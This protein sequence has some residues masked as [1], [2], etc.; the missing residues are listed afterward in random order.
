MAHAN[1]ET[2]TPTQAACYDLIHHVGADKVADFLGKAAKSVANEANPNYPDAKLGFEDMVEIEVWQQDYR[3]LYA[4][5][6]RCHHVCLP[7]P[8][9]ERIVADMAVLESFAEWQAALGMTCQEIRDAL[10]DGK[11]TRAEGRRITAAFYEHM[12]RGLEFLEHVHAIEEP[13]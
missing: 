7:L 1:R 3:P 12:K 13:N 11:M 9:P 4:H 8:D 5:A 6:Q 10:R 2:W